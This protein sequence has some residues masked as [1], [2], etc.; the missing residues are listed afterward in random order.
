MSSFQQYSRFYPEVKL[1][2]LTVVE[3]ERPVL[4]VGAT[5]IDNTI[6]ILRKQRVRHEPV[7]RAAS[8]GDRVVIDF[9]G[10]KGGEPFPGG[11]PMITPS[12]SVK[13]PCWLTLKMP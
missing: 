2:D 6:E 11:R 3:I 5:E 8:K 4:V 10:K 9:L 1:G 12:F 13:A 7:E